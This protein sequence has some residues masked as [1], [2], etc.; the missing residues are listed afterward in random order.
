[1]TSPSATSPRMTCCGEWDSLLGKCTDCPHAGDNNKLSSGYLYDAARKAA[2]AAALDQEHIAKQSLLWLLADRIHD[3]VHAGVSE[4]A[5]STVEKDIEAA[6]RYIGVK[7]GVAPET[8]GAMLHEIRGILRTVD[9]RQV[10]PSAIAE[11]AQKW[12]PEVQEVLDAIDKAQGR[13]HDKNGDIC[14]I[15]VDGQRV[16]LPRVVNGARLMVSTP[17]DFSTH[18]LYQ[19]PADAHAFDLPIFVLDEITLMDGYCFYTIPRSGP[20]GADEENDRGLKERAQP[21]TPKIK[22]ADPGE[23][24]DSLERLQDRETRSSLVELNRGDIIAALRATASATRLNFSLRHLQAH[25]PWTIPYS[26]EFEFSADANGLRRVGHDVLHVMKSLGR[27]AAEVEGADHD[28]PR[29]LTGDALAKEAADLVLCA[30]HIARCEGF[31]LQDAV[32]TNSEAR[33]ATQIQ[34]EYVNGEVK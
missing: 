18:A 16:T 15:Y 34:P 26:A 10:T 33:N 9:E 6:V 2:R 1:M 4:I 31:D 25:L 23:L 14:R 3:L 28:R 7:A 17:N 20:H 29:K 11:P 13:D 8:Y 21:F 19:E 22:R 5:T 30:L 24:A 27:I 32:V 12:R